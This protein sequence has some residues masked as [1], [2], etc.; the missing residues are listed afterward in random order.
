M[1]SCGTGRLTVGPFTE[2]PHAAVYSC[3][4]WFCAAFNFFMSSSERFARAS[5]NI[6]FRITAIRRSSESEQITTLEGAV[7]WVAHQ[8]AIS[9]IS[10]AYANVAADRRTVTA[11]VATSMEFLNNMRP[12]SSPSAVV[13]GV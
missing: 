9:D 3:I 8:S 5:A 12:L 13:G 10:S 1:T 11:T 2:A 6:L 7:A 4:H